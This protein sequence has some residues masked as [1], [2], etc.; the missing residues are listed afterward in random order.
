M[1]VVMRKARLLALAVSLIGAGPV[2]GAD[3]G[4]LTVS[5][6]AVPLVA[7][8]AFVPRYDAQGWGKA[9]A[10]VL[11]STLPMD[12]KSIEGWVNPATGAFEQVVRKGRGALV[13]V[14]FMPGLKPGRVSVSGVG[15]TLGNDPCEGCALQAA[16]SGAGLKGSVKTGCPWR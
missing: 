1:E 13:E 16:Y 3:L 15:Y 2:S 9:E 7:A 14:S 5:G 4:S 12:G 10:I 8:Y 11:L 6:K